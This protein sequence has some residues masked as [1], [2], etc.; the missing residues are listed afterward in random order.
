ME[1][2]SVF[3]VVR[4][5]VGWSVWVSS[6]LWLSPYL[7]SDGILFISHNFELFLDVLQLVRITLFFKAFS[8]KTCPVKV[9]V[10]VQI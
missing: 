9:C 1:N 8:S 2:S 4:G 10:P 3:I 5:Y 6:F 7:V